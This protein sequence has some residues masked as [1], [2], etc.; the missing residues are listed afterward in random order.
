MANNP[1]PKAP[2]TRNR[3]RS[4]GKTPAQTTVKIVKKKI[5]GS[6]HTGIAKRPVTAR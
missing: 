4:G 1:R 6:T 5:C 2:A 3:C